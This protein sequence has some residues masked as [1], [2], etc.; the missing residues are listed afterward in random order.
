MLITLLSF[1]SVL[2][3]NF[4]FIT[5]SLDFNVLFLATIMV[6]SGTVILLL[7][8]IIGVL[9]LAPLQRLEHTLI[10][11]LMEFFRKDKFFRV[12]H[13]FLF[14][15]PF[16]SYLFAVALLLVVNPYKVML[17]SFW[18]LALG[19]MLDLLRYE[20]KRLSNFLNPFH[21][22][23]MLKRQAR[24]AVQDE[25]DD[26]LWG[27]L[28]TLSEVTLRAIERDQLA[29]SIDALN[30]FPPIM[31]TFFSSSKSI[32]RTNQDEAIEK[33]TSRDEASYTVFYLL[34][35]LQSISHKAIDRN[36]ETI[37]S[38]IV[39]VLGK[40][41]VY[42]AQLDLSM[43]SFPT[44]FLG[45][46]ALKAQQHQ[47]DEV[48][49]MTISTLLEISKTIVT[50]IDITYAELQ[51]P[52]WT[53]IHNLDDMAKAAF[54]KDKNINIQLLTQPLRDLKKLFQSE[55][56]AKHQDTPIIIQNIDSV[57]AEFDALEQVMRTLP[58]LSS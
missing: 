41:I 15:F 20:I 18:I 26:I 42:G 27:S 17:F 7:L 38:Q 10:P 31:H 51:D 46:F 43:V 32:S 13:F 39:L 8:P 54:K 19:S 48:V 34:Q 14:L 57:L 22:I 53:I 23:G 49:N 11:R 40:I 52:F 33:K 3:I 1:I 29:V 4:Y 21:L 28:D 50:D 5:N 36:L 16:L 30:T 24:K 45:Q 25:Q 2:L 12:S 58:P 47:L 35:R 37:C 56:I 55:K 44:H 9:A 6:V